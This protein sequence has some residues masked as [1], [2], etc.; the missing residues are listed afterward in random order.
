MQGFGGAWETEDGEVLAGEM[1]LLEEVLAG[2]S[3]MA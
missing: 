2:P 3:L 1:D